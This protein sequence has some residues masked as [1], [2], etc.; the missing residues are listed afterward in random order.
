MERPPFAFFAQIEPIGESSD[1]FEIFKK[2]GFYFY[3]FQHNQFCYLF[4][5]GKNHLSNSFNMILSSLVVIQELDTKKRKIRSIRGF[6]LYALEIIQDEK[7]IT[8][9]KTNFQPLFWRRVKNIIKQ[10]KRNCIVEF[11]FEAS[12]SI[13]LSSDQELRQVREEVQK[14]T[15]N[16]NL[17]ILSF[18]QELKQAL[19]EV[20][21]AISKMLLIQGRLEKLSKERD[22]QSNDSL[23]QQSSF[24]LVDPPKTD[25][26]K[27]IKTELELAH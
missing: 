5:Y 14:V 10:N 4:L 7:L 24:S 19:E 20:Q 12:N 13:S 8:V 3:Y 21:K 11:L 27:I 22:E 16:P 1:L 17:I 18:D 15:S 9:L 26:E 25:K 2:E 23:V 6:L